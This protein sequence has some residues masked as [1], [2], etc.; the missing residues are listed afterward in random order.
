MRIA[1]TELN[2]FDVYP[3]RFRFC[4]RVAAP[5][6]MHRLKN[7]WK[8][9]WLYMRENEWLSVVEAMHYSEGEEQQK[10]MVG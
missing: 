2:I 4:H 1:S 9:C 3:H 6:S 10:I 8:P 7:G 5:N